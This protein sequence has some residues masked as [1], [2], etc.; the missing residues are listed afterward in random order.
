MSYKLRNYRVFDEKGT[1]VSSCLD[2]P[3]DELHQW[4]SRELGPD[5]F[6]FLVPEEG[7]GRLVQK[8]GTLEN[9]SLNSIIKETR[10]FIGQDR[11]SYVPFPNTWQAD[12]P[13]LMKKIGGI[14]FGL[15]SPER[16]RLIVSK[17]AS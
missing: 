8:H 13:P 6:R 1:D 5:E 16:M 10:L 15:T 2:Q 4:A 9:I 12:N 14:F 11:L 7:V 17:I 3:I